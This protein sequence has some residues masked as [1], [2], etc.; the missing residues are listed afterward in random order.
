MYAIYSI[1]VLPGER[2]RKHDE[3]TTILSLRGCE[4]VFEE[5]NKTG[6]E[7]EGPDS[8]GF[9]VHG[10]DRET[11]AT[12]GVEMGC[13]ARLGCLQGIELSSVLHRGVFLVPLRPKNHN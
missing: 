13:S 6:R 8:S 10:D 9:V 1:P 3:G 4:R 11:T 12:D 2:T 7:R 5:K